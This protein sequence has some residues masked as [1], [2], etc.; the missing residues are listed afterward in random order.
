MKSQVLLYQNRSEYALWLKLIIGGVLA[1]TLILGLAI[2]STDT[3][4]AWIC[5]GVTVFDAVLFWVVLPQRILIY[6][7]RLVIKLGGPI[8]VNVPLDNI[9]EARKTSGWHTFVHWGSRFATSHRNVIEIIRHKGLS[10][11]I[12]PSSADEFLEQLKQARPSISV[13]QSV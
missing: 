13:N 4:A 12:S 2:L 5:L 1:F 10:I 6:E 11:T 7:D 9:K 3:E 8:S